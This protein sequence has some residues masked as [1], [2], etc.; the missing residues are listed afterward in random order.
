MRKHL[1]LAWLLAC[2]SL[3]LAQ[4]SFAQTNV[5]QTNPTQIKSPELIFAQSAFADPAGWTAWSARP[6][7]APQTSIDAQ[8]SRDSQGRGALR[9]DGTSNAAAYGGWRKRITGIVPGAHYSFRS[10]YRAERIPAENWQV[11]ALLDWKRADGERAGQPDYMSWAKRDGSWTLLEGAGLAPENATAVEIQL[12][13][14]NAPQATLWWDEI[15]LHRQPAPAP[16]KVVVASVNLRPDK[17]KSREENVRRFIETIQRN[18][19]A[20]ADLIVLP[21]GITV[22]GL[23]KPYAE[24]AEPV[25][26]P[27]VEMLGEVAKARRS[28]VVAG[29]YEREGSAIYNTSVLI[30]RNGELV[31]KYRKVYLPREEVERG[32]TPGLG[33]PV[34][35]TDFGK[36]GMMICYDVFF[37][38][39][40]RALATQGADLIAMPIWGGD[41]SLAKARAIE[42]GIYLVASG[43]DHPTYIM[44]PN[45]ER[46]SEARQR[47]EVAVAEIDLSRRHYDRW[48]GEMRTR[49]L[50]EQR[51]D[52]PVP[53]PGLMP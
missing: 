51:I 24:V 25:P 33:Y 3:V 31:G 32:L 17:Q 36:V 40:A 22:V 14:A 38:D 5:A 43:Y 29:L 42:N 45:G 44:H 41:E 7:I 34:F 50:K 2:S 47:G 53:V 4:T 48:L 12:Y 46:L 15:S 39:P 49:R 27:T 23:Y 28:Y 26:G 9:I 11:V 1:R 18:V 10:Y 21:E 52:V 13:L 19:P 30:G 35:P 37:S 6:E 16:R 20:N 8:V